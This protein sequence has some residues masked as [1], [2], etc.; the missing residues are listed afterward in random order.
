MPNFD[1]SNLALS[2]VCPGNEILYDDKGMPSIMVKI[3]KQTYKQLGLG[4]SEAVHPAF[5]VNGQ[6]V[7]AIWISKYQN[8]VDNGRAYSLPAQD[9]QASLTLILL[10]VTVRP[11]ARGGI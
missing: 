11:K 10:V 4:E 1:L 3:P 8:I 2:A 7:D 6:E 9:P 5:I